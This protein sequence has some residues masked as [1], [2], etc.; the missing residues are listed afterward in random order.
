M[1]NTDN[2]RQIDSRLL[3]RFTVWSIIFVPALI[4]N[5]AVFMMPQEAAGYFA[6]T[7][8]APVRQSERSNQMPARYF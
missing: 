2:R 1:K 5:A 4:G 7:I 3:D 8:F 6:N